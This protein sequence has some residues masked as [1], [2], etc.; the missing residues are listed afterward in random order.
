MKYLLGLIPIRRD[1]IL[2]FIE[3]DNENMTLNDAQEITDLV[4]EPIIKRYLLQRLEEMSRKNQIDQLKA[5]ITELEGQQ[6]K[7]KE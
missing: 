5:R 2:K 7:P 6:E 4:G 3:G 1:E